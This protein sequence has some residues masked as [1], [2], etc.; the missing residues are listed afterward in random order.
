MTAM[1]EPP[2]DIRS[3]DGTLEQTNEC[4][5]CGEAWTLERRADYSVLVL[6]GAG[7]EVDVSHVWLCH[8]ECLK[9]AAHPRFGGYFASS[10]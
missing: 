5:L 2:Q 9:A 10:S 6:G 4:L 3:E 8:I 7:G 1:A